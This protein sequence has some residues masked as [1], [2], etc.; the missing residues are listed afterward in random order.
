MNVHNLVEIKI[1]LKYFL[2]KIWHHFFKK[3]WLQYFRSMNNLPFEDFLGDWSSSA[4]KIERT[5]VI[6]TPDVP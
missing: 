2:S 1:Y 5:G 6:H 4:L 3:I